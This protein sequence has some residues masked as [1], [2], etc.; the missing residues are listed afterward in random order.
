MRPAIWD[1]FLKLTPRHVIKNPVM[2]VVEIGSV[3]SI[4]L[5]P[6]PPDHMHN[7]TLVLRIEKKFQPN[8]RTDSSA[9]LIT[10][11]LLGN[12]Y[13]TVKRGLTGSPIPNNGILPGG[14]QPQ[15]S[16]LVVKFGDLSTQV[17]AIL[18]KVSNGQGTLGK[19]L[20]DPGIYDHANDT[21]G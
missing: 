12:R 10:E 21:I 17:S 4:E 19:L 2:F 8:V 14:Q 13:V 11:G 20:N 6:Q 18:T 5:T 3:Q 1:S 9:S 16:D 15:M 7:I